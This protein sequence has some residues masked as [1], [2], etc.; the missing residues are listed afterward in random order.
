M[1]LAAKEAL[2]NALKHAHAK[3]IRVRFALTADGF[4]IG[5]EDDGR[6]FAGDAPPARAGAGNGL[7]NMQARMKAVGGRFEIESRPGA[8]TRVIFQV[9]LPR[10]TAD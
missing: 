9:P 6:G 7:E 1:F 2:N 3:R 4:E 5:I 10:G 8:G